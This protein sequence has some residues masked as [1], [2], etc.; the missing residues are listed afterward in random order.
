MGY[1]RHNAIVVT[2][3]DKER[4]TEAHRVAENLLP[5][6]VTPIVEGWVNGYCSFF[7]APDG[8]KE[9]WEDSAK[10]DE[11]RNRFVEW[12]DEQR[13]DD[14]STPFC[15]AE[16]VYSGDDRGAS[17]TRHAWTARELID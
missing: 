16:V 11:A 7:V 10:G 14:N 9:G 12:L 15:W 17:V 1:M 13:F 3:Y 4:A 6:L 8:S 5:G 2:T